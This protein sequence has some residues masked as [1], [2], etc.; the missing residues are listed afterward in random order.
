[1][2]ELEC[3]Q[4]ARLPRQDIGVSLRRT[5]PIALQPEAHG[6]NM[7]SLTVVRTG[8]ARHE[9]LVLLCQ[10]TL[11]AGIG[12]DEIGPRDE[13]SRHDEV[14]V[15]AQQ[16]EHRPHRIGLE[17]QHLPSG[18]GEFLDPIGVVVRDLGA[19]PVSEHG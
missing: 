4:I 13:A 14:G 3:A 2:A 18:R 8:L 9:L 16:L 11:H 1:M 6:A 5:V 12:G 10:R 19:E 15:L 7:T 17:T